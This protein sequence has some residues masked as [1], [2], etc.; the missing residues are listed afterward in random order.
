MKSRR[1]ILSSRLLS[2]SGGMFLRVQT[3]CNQPRPSSD[4]VTAVEYGLFV[5]TKSLG[6]CMVVWTDQH[7]SIYRSVMC[8]K[9]AFMLM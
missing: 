9:V 2:W 4:R 5:S 7:I 6:W 1:M 8:I 3:G